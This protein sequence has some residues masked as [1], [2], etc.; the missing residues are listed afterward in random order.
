MSELW[1]LSAL[2]V[3]GQLRSGAVSAVE[4]TRAALARIDDVDDALHAFCTRT[5]S[6]ALAQAAEVDARRAAGEPLGPLAG[7]PVAVKDL[8][9][10]AGIRT[11]AGT[12]AYRDLVP[13]EDDVVVERLKAAGAVITGKTNVSELG[14]GPVGHNPVFETTRNPW[15]PAL[16]SGGS[17][18]GSAVAVATGMSAL[19]L[20]SDGGGSIRTPASLCGVVGVKASMGRVPL[21]PGCRDPRYPGLSSWESLEHIGPLA[22]SVRDAALLLSVIAGPDPR[23]RHSIPCADVDW[24]GCLDG[25]EDGD[26]DGD[27]RG[28][29]I[30]VSADWGYARV[31]PEVRAIITTAAQTFAALGAEV[32]EMTAPWPD[33]IDVFEV[34]VAHDTDLTGM[35]AMADEFGDQMSPH[36]VELVRRPWSGS[37]FTDALARRQAVCNQM[38]RLM[39]RYDLLLTPVASVPAFPIGLRGPSTIDG[40]PAQPRDWSPFTFVAN[41]TGQPAASVPAGLTSDG[42][43]VG[44]HLIGRHLADETVLRA[45][46]AFEAAAGF[47]RSACLAAASP[48]PL[49][50][51]AR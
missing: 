21:Y 44:L 23:D 29:R 51:R 1:Q 12:A 40:H 8:I 20:G 19:A 22:R 46:A 50:S 7:V 47:P 33:L 43:P 24:L 35:R 34:I 37:E 15:N 45:S 9:S 4:V 14:Y 42:L 10:T 31:D 39:A 41:L 32:E 36:L 18:A 30:G 49:P 27:V 48:P 6:L 25:D 5:D 3:A 28:L 26:G 38:W 11:T 13:D 16:T 17:S 2:E